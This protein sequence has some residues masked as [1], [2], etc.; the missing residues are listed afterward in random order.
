MI[1]LELLRRAGVD[2][3]YGLGAGRVE[4]I[5]NAW[6]EPGRAGLVDGA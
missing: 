5:S 6:P 3:R 2:S 1:R 4:V